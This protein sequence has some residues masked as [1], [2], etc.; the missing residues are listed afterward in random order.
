MQQKEE[1]TD[2]FPFVTVLIK[3]NFRM[4]SFLKFS[5]I[6]LYSPCLWGNVSQPIALVNPVEGHPWTFSTNINKNRSD[7]IE[8]KICTIA[9]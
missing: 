7:T 6:K 5:Y 1:V 2:A 4:K 9:L 3:G 8:A